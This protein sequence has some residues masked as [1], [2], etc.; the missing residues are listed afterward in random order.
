MEDLI[1]KM[2]FPFLDNTVLS[3]RQYWDNSYRVWLFLSIIFF[4]GILLVGIYFVIRYRY[5][6]GKNEVGARIYGNTSLEVIWIVIP[7]I[8]AIFLGTYSFANFMYQRTLP[9][10]GIQIK[11]TGFMW[12]WEVEYENGKV[13][14][15]SFDPNNPYDKPD[16][17]K[18]YLP[19]GKKIKV[20]MTSRDVIHSFYVQPAMITEDVIPGRITYMWFQV[21]KEGEYFAFC[22]E[23]CGTWHSGMIA[24]LK[25]VSQEEFEEWLK[26]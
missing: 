16:E 11:V 14:V 23:Y 21:D 15:T 1:L 5:V 4:F 8:L 20:F 6:R 12:G 2:I 26:K 22:R 25:F 24:V 10:D 18:V 17:E 9:A 7:T 13:V 19:V 3:S